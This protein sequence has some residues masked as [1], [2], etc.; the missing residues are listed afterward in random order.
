M[1]FI[2]GLPNS[3]TRNSILVVVDHLTKYGHFLALMHPCTAKDV[4]FKYLNQ[5]YKLYDMPDSII[6]DWD[7]I[8]AIQLTPYEALY[9]QPP[10]IHMPYL[11]GVSPAAVVDRSLQSREATRKLL[12]F[13]LKRAQGRMKHFTDKHRSE[14]SFQ[15]VIRKVGAV[16]YT[17]QFPPHSHIHP[18]FHVS[19]LKKHVKNHLPVVDA[20]GASPKEPIRIIDRRM[21]KKGSQ[22]VT[23]V[24]VKW[25]NSFPE[26]A[27]WEPLT[28]FQTKFPHFQP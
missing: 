10:P 11:A 13:C 4:A 15:E 9:G 8:F 17:L 14:R 16:A 1:D 6:S 7:Q 25:A 3:N 2:E 23:E 19:Q 27:T 26:D 24:L 22:A 5:V 28:A 21:V 18:T 20:H 12:M